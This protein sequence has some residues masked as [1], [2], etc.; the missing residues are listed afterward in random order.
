MIPGGEILIDHGKKE[1][2]YVTGMGVVNAIADSIPEFEHGLRNGHQGFRYLEGKKVNNVS[3]IG[4]DINSFSFDNRMDYY[5]ASASVPTAFIDRAGKTARRAPLTMKAALSC[6]LEAYCQAELFNRAISGDRI[7]IIVTGSNL[8]YSVREGYFDKFQKDPEYLTPQYALQFMDTDYIGTLSELF[9]IFGEGFTVGGASASGNAGI[10]K[11]WQLL[12]L[13]LADACVVVGALTE[14]TNMELQGFYNI[15]AMGGRKYYC[16]PEKACR[17]FDEEHEGFL[18][19]QASGCLILESG[20]SAEQRAVR[21]LAEILGGVINLD[22]NRS[23]NPSLAGEIKAMAR[24]LETAGIKP[25]E[26][27]YINAHGSSSPLG[28]DTE[29]EAIKGVYKEN[30]SRIIINSTKGLTGHCLF[31]AGVVE[32]IAVILQ[33]NSGF[34]HPNANLEKPSC[35]EFLFAGKIAVPAS[36]RLAMSNSFGFGGINTSILIKGVR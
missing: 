20:R 19:G 31:S 30:I 21:P 35:H 24:T 32:A 1:P 15:G 8:T 29:L 36:I 12:Q 4:A 33:M 14:L 28:D 13:G 27:D 23:S 11:A 2:V 22:G 7:A 17:P 6:V 9:G 3:I 34:I 5:G 16:E 18:Y 26:V 25:E 10:I